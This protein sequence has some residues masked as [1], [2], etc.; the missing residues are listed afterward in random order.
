MRLKY[1]S[2]VHFIKENKIKT[3][4]CFIRVFRLLIKMVNHYQVVVVQQKERLVEYDSCGAEASS[5]LLPSSIIISF[6]PISVLYVSRHYYHPSYWFVNDLQ[7]KFLEP[8]F[9]YCAQI[10]ASFVH[11]TIRCHSVRSAS[12]FQHPSI[13]PCCNRKCSNLQATF[14]EFVFRSPPRCPMRVTLFRLFPAIVNFPQML[15]N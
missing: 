3:R 9:K 2:N 11:A 6:I 12:Y 14:C 1:N 4:M 13:F 15:I 5:L 8:F 7:D 10:S